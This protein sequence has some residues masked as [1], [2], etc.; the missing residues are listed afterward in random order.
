MAPL[1]IGNGAILARLDQNT[2]K[3]FGEGVRGAS[4]SETALE[5][6]TDRARCGKAGW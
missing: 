2:V 3:Q 6:R 5:P 1:P 4:D